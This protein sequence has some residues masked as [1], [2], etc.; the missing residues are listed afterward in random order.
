MLKP[1]L[2]LV[3]AIALQ[4]PV[5][6]QTGSIEGI[7]IRAGS[8]DPLAK[9]TVELAGGGASAQTTATESDGR[10]FFR[11]LPPGSYRINVTR[12]GFAPAEYGQ[13]WQGGPGVPIRLNAGQPV[14]PVQIP[15][16]AAAS[17]SGRVSDSNGKP[18]ANAQVQAL[19][20]RF[21][22]ELRVLLPVQQVRTTATGE[23]RLYWLPAGRYY[24]NVIVPGGSGNSQILVNNG[25]R[26]DSAAPYSTSSQPRS[27]LGQSGV[28]GTA[29][30]PGG[31]NTIDSG[32]IYFPSTP[33]IQDAA[34]IDLRP[35][36]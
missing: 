15:L 4:T 12:D 32:P 9:A 21:H 25:G 30:G 10:F 8:N 7:V 24:V 35:G 14:A 33:Y 3:G 16:A 19:K 13:R 20:S 6:Q 22:G 11:N 5:S 18:L 26:T 29:S 1:I 2:I 27:V 36:T 34:P 17:I 31:P 28:M 23:F